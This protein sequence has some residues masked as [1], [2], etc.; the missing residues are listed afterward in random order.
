MC[1]LYVAMGLGWLM[2]C[3]LHWRD[4]LRIQFWIGAVI[5]LGM[6]EKAMFY[7]EFQNIN[8][9]GIPTR[10]LIVLAEVV[11]CAKRTLARYKTVEKF[12][13]SEKIFRQINFFRMLVIIVSLGFGIVKPRLGP[14]LH[15]IVGIGFLYFIIASTEAVLRVMKPKNDLSSGTMLAGIPL[16]VIDR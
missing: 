1:G 2:V 11:S 10:S 4:L 14:T 13:L 16:A 9:T 3:A 5:F 8:S 6:L 15:R 12:T 7:A